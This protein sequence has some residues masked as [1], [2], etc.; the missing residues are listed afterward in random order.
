MFVIDFGVLLFSSLL[1]VHACV[2]AARVLIKPS[3]QRY[4]F[5]HYYVVSIWCVTAIETQMVYLPAAA[6]RPA[7]EL[8][9]EDALSASHDAQPRRHH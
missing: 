3:L 8:S 6:H 1:T 9:H 5:R 4:D 7:P 2:R